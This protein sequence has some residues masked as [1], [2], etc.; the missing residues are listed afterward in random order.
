M[1]DTVVDALKMSACVIVEFRNSKI[2]MWVQC[3]LK[4]STGKTVDTLYSKCELI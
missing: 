1:C 2:E 4:P 3:Q